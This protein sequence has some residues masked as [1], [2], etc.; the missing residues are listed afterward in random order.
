MELP[1]II[2]Y[3]LRDY[4]YVVL[5]GREQGNFN[6]AQTDIPLVVLFMLAIVALHFSLLSWRRGRLWLN[7]T[8]KGFQGCLVLI[9]EQCGL[10]EMRVS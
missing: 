2:T 3:P 8:P 1:T 4:P 9:R 5:F 6:G 10:P 7:T